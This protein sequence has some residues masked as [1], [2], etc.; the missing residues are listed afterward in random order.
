MDYLAD[1]TAELHQGRKDRYVGWEGI[2][3]DDSPREECEPVVV[4]I[5]WD[6]SI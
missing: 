5:S 1:S 3:M 4:F 2:P 6:L